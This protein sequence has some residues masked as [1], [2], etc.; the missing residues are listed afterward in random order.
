MLYTRCHNDSV[1]VSAKD[2]DSGADTIQNI[3]ENALPEIP[4]I[5]NPIHGGNHLS[6]INLAV[7]SVNLISYE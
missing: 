7:Y 2:I 6:I 4:V 3:E 5:D 1:A